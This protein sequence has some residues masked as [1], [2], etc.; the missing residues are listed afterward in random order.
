MCC[1]DNLVVTLSNS[2]E[3]FTLYDLSIEVLGVQYVTIMVL[4]MDGS[5]LINST[6]SYGWQLLHPCHHTHARVR[7][8]A[9]AA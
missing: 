1:S 7:I 4:A 9:P 8:L 5:A 2:S 3:A 6:V